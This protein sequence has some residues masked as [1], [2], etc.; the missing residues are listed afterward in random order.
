MDFR[1][2]NEP[3]MAEVEAALPNMDAPVM[4]QAVK[5]PAGLDA[6]RAAPERMALPMHD[7]TDPGSHDLIEQRG[8]A[9][10]AGAVSASA[11]NAPSD[12]SKS[13]HARRFAVE[14]DHARDGKRRIIHL[15]A[16][17]DAAL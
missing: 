5:A 13:I 11:I 16:I 2:G 17:Q 15:R 12:D 14:V 7:K 4:D 1:N 3:D 8:A 6:A 10:L 9:A